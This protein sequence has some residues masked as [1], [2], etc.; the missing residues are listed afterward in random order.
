M[1]HNYCTIIS[2]DSLYQ[3]LILYNS[4]KLHDEDFCLF[5]ICMQEEVK[6]LLE[7]MNLESAKII[8]LRDIEEYDEEL[9]SIKDQ[10]NSKE[11]AWTCKSSI[12]LYLF[13]K[14]FFI[15]H[16]IYIDSDVEFFSSTEAIYKEFKDASV[17]LTRERFYIQDNESWYNQYGIYNGGFMAFKRDKNAFEAL[18]WMREQCIK[19]CFNKVENNLYGDQKY[20]KDWTER[21]NGVKISENLGI[22]TTAWYAHACVLEEENKNKL[23]NNT[24]IIFYHYN[25]FTMYNENEFELCIFIKLPKKLINL[26]YIP[27]IKKLKDMIEFVKKYDSELYDKAVKDS[28]GRVQKNYYVI[29][30]SVPPKE[31]NF[32][33]L[34][35]KDYLIKGLTLYNSLIKQEKD[36]HLWI[37]CMDD[38]SFNSLRSMSLSNAS[39]IK[40]DS[41]EDSE[42]LL[43]K[44]ERSLSEYCWTI[45]ST[46]IMYLLK[47]YKNIK[48]LIYLDGDLFFFSGVKPIFS[49]LENT[50]V[51]L[52]PQRD[53][54][55][56][57]D[58]FGKY[59]AGFIG[60]K[61]D[62]N[63]LT[64]LQW[65]REKCLEWCSSE[66]GLPDKWGDQKY[67]DS[68]PEL[69]DGIK[70]NSHQGINAA[71]WNAK[72]NLKEDSGRLYIQRI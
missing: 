35:A 65:W 49:E 18:K 42:L 16:I 40:A 70:I 6:E 57:E 21:F 38:F 33:T 52:F 27:Y 28:S 23:I 3:G 64:C 29:T 32:C 72:N 34:I 69:F 13:E 63:A 31:Y 4:L 61:N 45:K 47:T 48:S 39:L 20:T 53:R 12:M 14:Q 55:F 44:D 66:Q 30:P 56:V 58:Q 71:V 8:D 46:W 59:Q 26:I 68:W 62:A 1:I 25:G 2:R 19:W 10:R 11:Y 17:L 67:L 5:I 9:S 50:S 7:L 51:L 54:D 36:F 37:C 60:F 24:P 43:I 15:D 41:I 22:N